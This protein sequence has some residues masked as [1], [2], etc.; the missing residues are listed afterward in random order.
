MACW[1]RGV[2]LALEFMLNFR[3]MIGFGLVLSGFKPEMWYGVEVILVGD[4]RSR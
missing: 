4:W 1:P 3:A 2:E